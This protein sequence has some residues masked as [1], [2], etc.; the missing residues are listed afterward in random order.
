M[1]NKIDNSSDISPTNP[2]RGRPRKYE[3]GAKAHEKEVKYSTNYY[4]E[5]KNKTCICECCESEIRY[6]TKHQ[7]VKSKT[8]QLVKALKQQLVNN[9]N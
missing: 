2:K 8:C 9:N 6:I 7:H 1:D 3:Q 4:R 5:N